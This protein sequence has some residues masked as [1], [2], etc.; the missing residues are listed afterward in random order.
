MNQL[1][2]EQ[3]GHFTRGLK[4][5]QLFFQGIGKVMRVAGCSKLA[6]LT[7]G[8]NSFLH[9]FQKG[10]SRVHSD[11]SA[12]NICKLR[13]WRSQQ[14]SSLAYIEN[15]QFSCLLRAQLE[16]SNTSPIEWSLY[17]A[18]VP[19]TLSLWILGQ[20]VRANG[21]THIPKAEA[22]AHPSCVH[23][24]CVYFGKFS[25][26]QTYGQTWRNHA[27]CRCACLPWTWLEG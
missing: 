17:L 11:K 22:K 24:S 7:G 5:I 27:F 23:P 16:V 20:G 1:W 3:S 12:A 18:L 8:W 14:P 6:Y 25:F 13:Q 15:M 19:L 26:S 9:K 21:F 10:L 2:L 4:C